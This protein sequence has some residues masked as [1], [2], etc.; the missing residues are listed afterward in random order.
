MLVVWDM[1]SE[2]PEPIGEYAGSEEDAVFYIRPDGSRG[3]ATEDCVSV[4]AAGEEPPPRC[5]CGNAP[6]HY[7]NCALV[8]GWGDIG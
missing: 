5:S 6:Y 8:R 3:M 1:E 7:P 4:L 2:Q